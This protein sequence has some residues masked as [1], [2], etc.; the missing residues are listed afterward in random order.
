[1]TENNLKHYFEVKS[2]I[3]W[4]G[5][6]NKIIN[7]LE[8]FLPADFNNLNNITYVEPFLGGGSFLFHI[9]RLPHELP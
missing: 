8:N 7:L 1:M 2:F 5:G 6:K 9:F 3:A 4:L